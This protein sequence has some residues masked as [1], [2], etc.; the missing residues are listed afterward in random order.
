MRTLSEG[1]A[2]VVLPT[3]GEVE[4]FKKSEFRVRVTFT[5][6]EIVEPVRM[7]TQVQFTP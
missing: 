4:F 5:A 1:G 7:E 6:L 3:V 2:P